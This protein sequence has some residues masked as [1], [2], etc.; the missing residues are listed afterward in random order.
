MSFSFNTDKLD[1]YSIYMAFV[2]KYGEPASF[3]PSQAVWEDGAVRVSIEKPLSVKYIDRTVFD[4]GV[5][6]ARAGESAENENRAAL[7]GAF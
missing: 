5:K 4:A 1:Y 3:N 6:S 2:K 7:L